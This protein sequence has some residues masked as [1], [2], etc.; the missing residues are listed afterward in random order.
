[1]VQALRMPMMGNTMET[2]LL[3]EWVVDEGDPVEADQVVAVVE[4]EKAAADVVA[5]R[6]GTLAR[7]DV[8]EGAEVPPGTLIG[9]VLGPDEGLGDAPPPRSRIEPDGAD[10]DRE[11]A[12]LQGESADRTEVAAGTRASEDDEERASETDGIRAAPGAR[13]LA[14]E[15]GI[16]LGA[17]EGTG[18]D[19]AVLIADVEEHVDGEPD[20]EPATPTD[21][22]MF[23]PPSTRR[24]ARELGVD[25]GAVEGT[26]ADGRVTE[27]DVRAAAGATDAGAATRSPGSGTGG[28]AHGIAGPPPRD[29]S[30]LGVTVSEERELAG[31]RRTVAERMSRSARDAP[32]VTLNREVDVE[33]AFET[34]EELERASSSRREESETTVGFTD[35]LVAAV[36][37]ALE[38]HPEFNAWYEGE[39]LRLIE[40]VNVAVA[41]DAAAG[42]LTPVVRD[43]GS[44]TLAGIARERR[45]LTDAVL[46]GRHGMDDLKG[47]TFTVS[48]LGP[49]GVDSFDPI[50]DPPQVAILGVGRVVEGS[51]TLSLTFDHRVA[52]GADAARF[53]DTLTGGLESPSVVV[54]ERAAA[55]VG[56]GS[57]DTGTRPRSPTSGSD[58]LESIEA[59]V[60]A[61]LA[62]RAREV[63]AVHGWPVPA[64]EVR[65]GGDRPV[66]GVQGDE[67]DSPATLS[68]LTYAA[69]RESRFAGTVAGLRDPEIELDRSHPTTT[70][71]ERD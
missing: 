40:E 54:A 39:A 16:D 9:V 64:F 57:G 24:L 68:R 65:L 13:R 32:Q 17:V 5:K 25:P 58:D 6:D 47:G 18:P 56:S 22:P 43:A 28:Q 41:V 66:V 14:G 7:V 63:A 46:D 45:R 50:L 60:A 26:G 23:L 36:V 15:E 11:G 31:V 2:G 67:G 70:P 20:P 69:C 21:G 49:F 62:D 71:D 61:D 8:E 42:L 12:A 3:A 4:S 19:G 10:G 34:V 48:N 52:D 35:L 37:R 38:R 59:A 51:C 29:P 27:S 53:L 30:R 1:M 55:G 33:R 44:R